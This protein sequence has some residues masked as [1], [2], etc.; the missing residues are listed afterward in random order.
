LTHIQAVAATKIF[1]PPQNSATLLLFCKN[2]LGRH[3]SVSELQVFAS[4]ILRGGRRMGLLE[5]VEANDA[6]NA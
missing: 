1:I 4:E 2:G 3:V 6:L 5:A